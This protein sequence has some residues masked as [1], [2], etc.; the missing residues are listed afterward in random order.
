MYA[1]NKETTTKH[2]ATIRFNYEPALALEEDESM[3][4]PSRLQVHYYNVEADMGGEL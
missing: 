2:I 1:G 3:A 4:N